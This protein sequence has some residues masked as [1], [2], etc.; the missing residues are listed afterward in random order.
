MIDAESEAVKIPKIGGQQSPQW[1][2]KPKESVPPPPPPEGDTSV[3]AILEEGGKSFHP[4]KGGREK[5]Y[6]ISRRRGGRGGGG[7]KKTYTCDFPIL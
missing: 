4:F 6:P 5:F 2:P 7:G 3:L 1:V